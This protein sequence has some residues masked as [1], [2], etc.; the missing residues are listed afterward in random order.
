MKKISKSASFLFVL[1]ALLVVASSANA[2]LISEIND[3]N[4]NYQGSI[5]FGDKLFSGFSVTSIAESAVDVSGWQ[6]GNVTFLQFQGNFV[7][8][9]TDQ[10]YGIRYAVLSPSLIYGIDQ[11]FNFSGGGT[12]DET[13][14]CGL[15]L[16]GENVYDTSNNLIAVSN[17]SYLVFPGDTVDDPDNPNSVEANDHLLFDGVYQVSVTKDIFLSA[18]DETSA[19]GATIITQSYHQTS[20]PEPSTLMLLGTGFASLAFFARRRRQ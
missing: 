2:I 12:C 7:A 10:D 4:G 19:V 16:I 17:L 13:G 9:G 5:V 3:P 6:D 11:S 20:V 14:E 8:I 18:Y 1:I 15:A